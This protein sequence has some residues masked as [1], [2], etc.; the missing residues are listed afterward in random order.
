[1]LS[2]AQIFTDCQLWKEARESRLTLAE[3]TKIGC[4]YIS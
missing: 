1:M 4:D 3:F 2:L